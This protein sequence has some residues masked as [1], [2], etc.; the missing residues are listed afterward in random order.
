[1][2]KSSAGLGAVSDSF[3]RCEEINAEVN[4]SSSI[5]GAVRKPLSFNR[6]ERQSLDNDGYVGDGGR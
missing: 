4:M 5:K 2:K 6:E 3:G 1:M